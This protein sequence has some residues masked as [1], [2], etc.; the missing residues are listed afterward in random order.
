MNCPNCQAEVVEG[1]AFCHRCGARLTDPSRDGETPGA[2]E[3]RRPVARVTRRSGPPSRW[4]QR[5][6]SPERIQAANEGREIDLWS[7]TFSAKALIHY[8][9]LAIAASIIVP[10]VLWGMAVDPQTWY[11]STGLLLVMW[12]A[13][14]LLVVFRKLDVRYELTS[15]RFIH[16]VGILRRITNRV[17]VIDI[18][19]VT[20]TQGIIERL[21]GIGTIEVHSTDRSNPAVIMPGI[22]HVYEIAELIDETRRLERHRRGVHI[23]AI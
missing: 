20:V 17:E 19:D 1:G 3:R 6:T 2:T 9:I 16:K 8:W 11:I 23:E 12:V 15:Q 5:L 18:D 4:I 22:D 7:G 14:L 13:L 21:L 10:L